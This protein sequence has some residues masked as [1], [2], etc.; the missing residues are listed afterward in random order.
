M[1]FQVG[2][3]FQLVHHLVKANRI[4]AWPQLHWSCFTT[5]R[6]RLGFDAAFSPARIAWFSVCLKDFRERCISSFSKRSTSCSK[7]TVVL[8]LLS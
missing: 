3:Y 1:L 6:S 2:I 4:N 7:E 5:K 8:I